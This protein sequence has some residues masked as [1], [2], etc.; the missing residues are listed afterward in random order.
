MCEA[1]NI[2]IPPLCRYM[3]EITMVRN[4]ITR[5][6]IGSHLLR[7]DINDILAYHDLRQQEQGFLELLRLHESHVGC[8]KINSQALIKSITLSHP[9][10][11]CVLI[12]ATNNLRHF[13]DSHDAHFAAMI[14]R[15]DA[16]LITTPANYLNP[17]D[18]K[19]PED[20]LTGQ[21][22]NRLTHIWKGATE[23]EAIENFS[24]IEGGNW[25]YA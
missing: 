5:G 9:E 7:Q 3:A 1:E 23:A 4:S 8:C 25:F 6:M 21:R 11:E 24:R 18:L 14:F 10:T 20:P 2:T 16:V 22:I 13:P 12:R 17:L 15:R 19:F